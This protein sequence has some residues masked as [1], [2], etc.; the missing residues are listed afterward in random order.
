MNINVIFF[1]LI[2]IPLSWPNHAAWAS[3]SNCKV[4]SVKYTTESKAND[5]DALKKKYQDNH[6]VTKSNDD[7]NT[8]EVSSESE[9]SAPD[10]AL[11][12]SL[13]SHSRGES[14]Y[15]KEHYP[16]PA[17]THETPATGDHSGIEKAL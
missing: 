3:C 2:A 9:T 1:I 7:E 15:C 4:F 5:L 13:V 8:F 10:E 12:R 6:F 16:I 17:K 11:V 14:V